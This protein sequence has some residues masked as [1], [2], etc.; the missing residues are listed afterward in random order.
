MAAY[1]FSQILPYSSYPAKFD[2][3]QLYSID[4]EYTL[5][6]AVVSGDTYTTP[7]NAL[8]TNGIRIVDTQ[9]VSVA[10]DTNASPT[11]TISVGDSGSATRFINAAAAGGTA[12]VV[13]F[14]NQAQGLTN[15][16]VSSGS[17][18]LYA[19]G[20]APQIV[21]TVGGTVATAQTTGTIRLRVSFYC[22]GEQ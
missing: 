2:A 16:V 7:A 4:F 14:I 22:T 15:G 5:A 11:A 17:G 10:L 19:S 21:V 6:G 9:L 8:P 13:R 12:Q 18:Y 1:N 3:G 20:T